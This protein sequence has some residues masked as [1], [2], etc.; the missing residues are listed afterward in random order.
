MG[1]SR[2]SMKHWNPN[3]F[4]LSAI[5]FVWSELGIKCL[6]ENSVGVGNHPACFFTSNNL[7]SGQDFIVRTYAPAT[8]V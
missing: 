5:W 2:Y 1:E 4:C 8:G 7:E 3:L 6:L